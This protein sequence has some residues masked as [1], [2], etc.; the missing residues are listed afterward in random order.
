MK[1]FPFA[2]SI[3]LFF[4]A[5]LIAQTSYTSGGTGDWENT[6]TWTPNGVPGVGDTAII[7]TGTITL[8]DNVT[9]SGLYMSAG[10]ITGDGSITITDS[11]YWS[12]GEIT[13][14][15][16]TSDL[17]PTLTIAGT[18]KANFNGDIN[19]YRNIIND[20]E[21]HWSNGNMVYSNEAVFENNG[22]FTVEAN[23][24][25]R[26]SRYNINHG[27]F[28]NYGSYIKLGAAINSIGI[29]FQNFGVV[30]LRSGR[31]EVAA[32]YFTDTGSYTI[33]EGSSIHFAN[34]RIFEGSIMGAGDV[35]FSGEQAY[36]VLNTFNITGIIDNYTYGK[37]TFGPGST[38]LSGPLMIN[39]EGSFTFNTG[40]T[41]VLDS[42][43]LNGSL[44]R[45]YSSDSLVVKKYAYLSGGI[46]GGGTGKTIID[47]D[48][49]VII[50]G[51]IYFLGQ[52]DNYGSIRWENGD[53]RLMYDISSG[54]SPIFNNYGLFI[55]NTAV[56]SSIVRHS[57]FENH[58]FNNFG[59]YQK[60]NIVS[61]EFADYITFVNKENGILKGVGNITFVDPI[62]NSGIVSPGDSVGVFNLKLD[63]PSESTSLINI[64]IGGAL[65]STQYDRLEIDGNANLKGTLNIEL[66]DGYIPGEGEVFEVMNFTSR[67]DTF[68]IVIGTE[69][70]NCRYFAVQYSDTAVNLEVI[71]VEPPQ[72][73]KDAISERQDRPVEV[74]VLANDTDP[75]GQTLSIL[76]VG[77]PLHGTAV[78]NSVSTI[79]YTPE[80]GFTGTD[81]MTYV[82][83]KTSGCIDSSW[84]VIDVLST[85]GIEELSFD[86]PS[87]FSIEQN[88]PNPFIESTTFNFSIPEKALVELRIFNIHGK[89][90]H[91]L[92]SNELPGGT[93]NYEWEV[94]DMIEGIYVYQFSA[95]EFFQTGKMFKLE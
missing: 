61:T 65:A 52:V 25:L 53:F 26:M 12:G 77:D 82:I 92:I 46:L 63:Y 58:N 34:G 37:V 74:N 64:E 84:I 90:I 16:I 28:R 3:F 78:V 48:A 75:D 81:S 56:S 95:N 55:D 19:I 68:D 57:G 94:P 80:T 49:K 30:D 4:N 24:Y 62:V 33:A 20:G 1:T 51:S 38:F 13:F 66:L 54:G 21:V 22:V 44:A 40:K 15:S 85:V 8:T 71:G 73:E 23:D 29:Y 93:Y 91:V 27:H 31:L 42:L 87:S 67:T 76:S 6:T 69:I 83:Q 18:A 32:G 17:K 35:Y 2:I 72:A 36:T 45:I 47:Q 39:L 5:S 89:L 70:S 41:I 11:L 60:K 50:P 79:L 9:I 14:S 88:Y 7:N 43:N 59:T 10:V 86:S